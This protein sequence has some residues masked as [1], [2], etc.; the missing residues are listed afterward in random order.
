LYYLSFELRRINVVI[1]LDFFI[2][3]FVGIMGV[4]VVL[5][6]GPVVSSIGLW[7]GFS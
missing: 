3:E 1:F 7:W 2:L 6:G 4:P 5:R